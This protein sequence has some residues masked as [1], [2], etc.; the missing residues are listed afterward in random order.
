MTTKKPKPYKIKIEDQQSLH[1]PS[2]TYQYNT[3]QIAALKLEAL[4]EIMDLN[5]TEL[6]RKIIKYLKRIKQN[7]TPKLI[8]IHYKRCLM[9]KKVIPSNV[10]VLKITLKLSNNV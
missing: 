5:Q 1:E 4:E 7:S 3:D 10:I 8:L 9:P 6:L 2:A